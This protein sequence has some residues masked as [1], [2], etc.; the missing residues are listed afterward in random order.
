MDD[1][2]PPLH[3]HTHSRAQ[4]DGRHLMHIGVDAWSF[5]L[6]T[7][8]DVDAWLVSLR[9]EPYEDTRCFEPAS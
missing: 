2:V 7:T 1:G 6:V 3:G 9:N 8:G 5:G 4:I